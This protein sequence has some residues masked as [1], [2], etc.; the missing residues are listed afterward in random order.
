MMTLALALGCAVLLLAACGSDDP[1]P[2]SF[3]NKEPEASAEAPQL[4]SRVPSNVKLTF[5][6]GKFRADVAAQRDYCLDKRTVVVVEL[7]KKHDVK[8]G[9]ITT[10]EDGF[11]ALAEK[12]AA[13]KFVGQLK[14]EPSASYGDVSICLGA[15]SKPLKV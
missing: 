9:K 1:V 2:R 8:V 6:H 4:P 11:G 7:G 5:K 14:K 3:D 13:G 15:S 10:D 12:K